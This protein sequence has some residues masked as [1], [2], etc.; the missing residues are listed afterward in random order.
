V[1]ADRPDDAVFCVFLWLSAG[2]GAQCSE[3]TEGETE[4]LKQGRYQ[5]PSQS[6]GIAHTCYTHNKGADSGLVSVHRRCLCLIAFVFVFVSSPLFVLASIALRSLSHTKNILYLLLLRGC[7]GDASL[8]R[9]PE[10]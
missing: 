8:G 10:A 2:L 4:A 1:S 5:S 6:P 3:A 9:E 7:L